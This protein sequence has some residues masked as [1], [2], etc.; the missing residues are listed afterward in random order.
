MTVCLKISLPPFQTTNLNIIEPAFN[1]DEKGRTFSRVFGANTG[2]LEHFLVKR[3]IM[4]PCWLEIKDAQMSNT[5]VS[6]HIFRL[7]ASNT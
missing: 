6:L 5:S 3:D 4:G 2:P 1:G 7:L